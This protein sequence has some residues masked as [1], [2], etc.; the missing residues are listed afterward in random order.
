MIGFFDYKVP[1][2]ITPCIA[3]PN[4]ENTFEDNQIQEIDVQGTGQFDE[5][6]I[7]I[8]SIRG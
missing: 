2:S 7:L 4:L 3:S 5:Y 8:I 6:L 1:P